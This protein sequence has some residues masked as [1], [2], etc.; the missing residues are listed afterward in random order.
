MSYAKPYAALIGIVLVAVGLLGFVSNPLVGDGNAIFLTGP[1]HNI[2]HLATGLLALGV[3]FG[4]RG[5][6][7]AMGVI[8]I[9]L[10]YLVIFV[11]LLVSPTLFG[12]LGA[13]YPVST[14]D[15]GLHFGLAVISLAVGWMARGQS[16]ATGLIVAPR[17]RPRF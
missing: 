17:G 2:V 14:A 12:I 1:V 7:Q 11:L 5:E 10:L 15:H 8:G 4:L 3:A 6:Q 16:M 13:A 9:G